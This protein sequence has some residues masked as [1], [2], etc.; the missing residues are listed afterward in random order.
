[1]TPPIGKDAAAA[2]AAPATVPGPC[3]SSPVL[4]SPVAPGAPE[5]TLSKAPTQTIKQDDAKVSHGRGPWP[6]TR[7]YLSEALRRQ[8]LALAR[9]GGFDLMG[10]ALPGPI[11]HPKQYSRMI[12][13]GGHGQMQY[14]ADTMRQ[15]LDS[16]AAFPWAKSIICLGVSYYCPEGGAEAGVECLPAS[17]THAAGTR[18]RAV[19]PVA[20]YA[21]GRDYHRVLKGLMTRLVRAMGELLQNDFLARVCVDTA[22]LHERDLAHAAG[23]GWIGK[24]TLLV[25]PRHGSWFVLGEIITDL[26]LEPNVPERDHC[27]TCTRCI[28]ACPTQALTPYKL[29]ALKCISYQTLENRGAIPTPLHGAMQQA[30]YLVGC[31]ICQ[32][33]CPYNRR[34]LV[35]RD[36]GFRAG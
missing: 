33:V 3:V 17:E 15:R 30:G 9:D 2:A 24:N 34:S 28:D 35:S 22:P 6:D 8:V 27:G 16:R 21:W 5:P 19:S 26:P 10:I 25:N 1:M 29:D 14:L 32:D 23:L 4:T 12:A 20:R 7:G 11:A 18:Q 31:D 13:G 36:E